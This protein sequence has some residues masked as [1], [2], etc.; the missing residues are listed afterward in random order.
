[1]LDELAHSMKAPC[2]CDLSAEAKDSERTNQ[3]LRP[4]ALLG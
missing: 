2:P 4:R 1:M 3:Y